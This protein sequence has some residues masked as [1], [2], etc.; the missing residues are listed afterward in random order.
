MDVMAL[1]PKPH[2]TAVTMASHFL[3]EKSRPDIPLGPGGALHLSDATYEQVAYNHVRISGP[4]WD[5]EP[6]GEYT[7]EREEAVARNLQCSPGKMWKWVCSL[8]SGKPLICYHKFSSTRGK[9]IH[10]VVSWYGRWWVLGVLRGGWRDIE[11]FGWNVETCRFAPLLK[12]HKIRAKLS[13]LIL[14]YIESEE[15]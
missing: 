11:G 15:G 5:P 7:L 14:R 4:R 1:D 12:K 10:W 2:M 6:E 13:R 8:D 9:D 3:Y